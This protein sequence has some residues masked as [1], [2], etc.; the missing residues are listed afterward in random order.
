VFVS[1]QLFAETRAQLAQGYSKDA[2]QGGI[3]WMDFRGNDPKDAVWGL[4]GE[5]VCNC[6]CVNITDNSFVANWLNN[7]IGGERVNDFPECSLEGRL[8]QA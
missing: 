6:I 1:V 2:W 5:G 4:F 3:G 7:S 8:S